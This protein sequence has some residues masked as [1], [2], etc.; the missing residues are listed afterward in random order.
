MYCLYSRYAIEWSISARFVP[1]LLNQIVVSA[2]KMCAP[3]ASAASKQPKQKPKT[4]SHKQA[5]LCSLALSSSSM[6]FLGAA[7][8]YVRVRA[9]NAAGLGPPF[10]LPRPIRGP[11]PAPRSTVCFVAH[12]PVVSRGFACILTHCLACLFRFTHMIEVFCA[13]FL[14][15]SVE[16]QFVSRDDVASD[17]CRSVLPC[18]NTHTHQPIGGYRMTIALRAGAATAQ[19]WQNQPEAKVRAAVAADVSKFLLVSGACGSVM[20]TGAITAL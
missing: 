4:R 9:R 10:T 12:A 2:A 7:S 13:L 15:G 6:P 5:L 1:A 11:K 8:Y 14:M 20:Q 16:Y 3:A 19:A 17:N 18:L